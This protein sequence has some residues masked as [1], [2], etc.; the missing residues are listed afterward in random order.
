MKMIKPTYLYIKHHAITGMNYFGKTTRNN[1]DKYLG[2]GKYWINHIN[3]HGKQHVITMWVSEP[4]VDESRL[5]E[6]AKL[7]SEEFNIV[8]SDKWANLREENG[9]DGA[10][11]G[12]SHSEESRKIMSESHKG[13]S[14]KIS[15]EAKK[16]MSEAQKKRIITKEHRDKIGLSISQNTKGKL[17][18]KTICPVCGVTGGNNVMKRWHFNN[19]KNNVGE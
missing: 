7:I 16:R 6:F 1:I 10:P 9:I 4:F 13:I 12:Y 11:I 2:S 18:P 14:N 5:V 3:K 17:K 15:D 19:C 8:N